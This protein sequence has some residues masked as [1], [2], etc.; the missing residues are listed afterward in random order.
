MDKQ[1]N[2]KVDNRAL[3]SARG[4]WL[5]LAPERK[6]RARLKDFTYGRQ[7]EDPCLSTDGRRISER[8][9][10]SEEG[11]L[12]VTNNILRQMVKSII[13]RYRY[14][15]QEITPAPKDVNDRAAGSHSL[16]TA[17][18]LAEPEGG[19]SET[20]CRALEEFLISGMII[21]RLDEKDYKN[22]PVNVSPELFF[23]QPFMRPDAS[24]CRMLGMLHDMSLACIMDKFADSDVYRARAITQALRRAH[25]AGSVIG[26]SVSGADF[27]TPRIP[28]TYRVIEL[29]RLRGYEMLRVKDEALD[30]VFMES[31]DALPRLEGLNR[32]RAEIGTEP[33]RWWHTVR[34]QWEC[35]WLTCGGEVLASEVCPPG[36]KPPFEMRFYPY[37]DGEV[38]SLVEDV[39][40]QQKYVNRLI[41]LLDHIISSSAKGVLL[42]P[43]DQLP[44]GFTWRDIRRIWSNPNGILPFRRTAKGTVP[45]QVCAGGSAGA[46]ATEMLKMQLQLFEQISG[47]TGAL[48]G[49]STSAQ[50]EGMLR[51]ELENAMVSMLDILATFRSFVLFRDKR[52]G[53]IW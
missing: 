32:T 38:H 28:D 34:E 36:F 33:L 2:L 8:Q 10:M 52:R 27:A 16:P 45:Q 46:G 25:G 29:W 31:I 39:V 49:K 22:E 1:I 3:E 4:A 44:E 40:D 35:M 14:M 48:S 13:G 30:R 23:H 24:D 19:V 5:A 53:E 9:R 11:R 21:Q 41:S 17:A 18:T 7:W 15:C 37:I 6:R 12:P 47:A 51:T 20:D 50:G 43:A 26:A 42:Y